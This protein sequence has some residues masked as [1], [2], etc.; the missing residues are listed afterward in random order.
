MEFGD[1]QATKDFDDLY[2]QVRAP[3]LETC[4]VWEENGPDMAKMRT[5]PAGRSWH[6]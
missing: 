5:N 2:R 1:W 4:Y 6:V 3:G